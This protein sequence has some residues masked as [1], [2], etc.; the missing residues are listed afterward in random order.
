MA[1]I[2]VEQQSAKTYETILMYLSTK[3]RSVL[4]I[5]AKSAGTVH[6]R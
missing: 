1:Y 5:L 2:T 6:A 3:E 4:P